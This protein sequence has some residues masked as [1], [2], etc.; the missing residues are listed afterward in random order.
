MKRLD[1]V[2]LF[3]VTIIA[4]L[5]SYARRLQTKSLAKVKQL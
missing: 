3:M 5:V 1:F 2:L 4:F